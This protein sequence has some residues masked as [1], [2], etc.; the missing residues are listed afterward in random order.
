[1]KPAIFLDR[2]GTINA[3]SGYVSRV[4]KL[5]F[6]EGAID[7]LKLLSGASFL[8]V[9]ITNQG[10]IA[11]GYHSVADVHR[12]HQEMDRVLDFSGVTIASFF[13]CP[14]HPDGVVVE[15]SHECE[16]RKPGLALY[17][18]AIAAHGIDV[19]RSHA[20]GDNVSDLIGP[21]ELGVPGLWL[22]GDDQKEVPGH[23]TARI[24]PV[25]GLLSAA[26]SIT[27]VAK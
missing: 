21:D 17:R 8:L 24:N 22:I 9:V 23:T 6:L 7:G 3:D 27:G 14:H 4:E 19:S 2:D 5:T 25:L 26:R 15:Y 1:M 20:I 12:F 10:G 16:C 18:E 13:H 11:R